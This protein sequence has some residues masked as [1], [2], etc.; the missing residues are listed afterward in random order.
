M[1]LI[2]NVGRKAWSVRGLVAALYAVLVIGAL[3]MVY[4]FL[5]MTSGSLKTNVDKNDFDVFPAFIHDDT[6]LYRKHI[7][8]KYNNRP[9][10]Y[11]SANRVKAYEFRTIEPPD[12]IVARRVADWRA[13]EAQRP[14]AATTYTLGYM[15]HYGDRLRLWK[16]RE[17]RARLIDL[18][19]G[20]IE[21]FVRRFQAEQ[22][23]WVTAGK[24]LE[25]IAS[26][27]YQLS[28]S[29]LEKEFYRFKTAQPAWF[30]VYPSLDGGFV[31]GYLEADYGRDVDK[32]NRLHGTRLAGL[33][34]L[35][36]SKTAPPVAPLREHLAAA[37]N[38]ARA[39]RRPGFLAAGK[40]F[41]RWWQQRLARND[42][43]RYVREELNLQFIAVRPAARGLFADFLR[44]RYAG[45]LD[46]L[47]KRYDAAFASFDQVPF[48]ADT[49]HAADRLV[50]WAEFIKTVPPE[51]L[52]LGGPEIDFRDFLRDTYA[53]DLAALN[54]AHQA[55]YTSFDAVPMP[56]RQ[57]DYA[58]FLEHK[59]EIRQ[60]FLTANYKQVVDYILLHGRSLLNTVIYCSLAIF[61]SLTINPLAAY[62]LSRYKIPSAY[63]VLLFCMATMAFPPAV[64]M[65]PNFLLLK[66]LGLLN[67]FAALVLPGMANGFSIF[68]LK[69][70]FDSLPRELYESAQLDGASEWVMF[71]HLTMALSKPILAVLAL[72]A[73]TRAYGNFMFAFILCPSEKMW[74]LMVFLYQLQINGHMSLTF[75]AL[76]VAAVP[77]FLV[78]VFCQNIIIR[79]IVVPVEK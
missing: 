62:A 39:A 18:C 54:A 67:T 75:A 66:E 17:F 1:P 49:T 30:R 59:A 57:V 65:I 43:R 53:G 72:G 47:N 71:W 74:T 41:V 14:P 44:A 63:K 76:L 35:T 33:R 70:F 34:D 6:V 22:T 40:A 27:R 77:T 78:F 50:D 42:W 46:Q 8:C 36:L 20:D 3:T 9:A 26:R 2:S 61:L 73:F 55:G 31:Q 32:Y 68:L 37:R 11:N 16:E 60:E 5:I 52:V 13:F 24:F 7:E 48:P 79:G 29:R 38:A 4:P 58:D 23:T 15:D 69:G 10:G 45:R 19:D 21:Q 28:G 51:H 12:R 56:T 25:S 64:T